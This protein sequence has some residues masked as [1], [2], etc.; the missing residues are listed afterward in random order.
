MHKMGLSL[1]SLSQTNVSFLSAAGSISEQQN[2]KKMAKKGF[3]VNF[4]ENIDFETYFRK[5]KV[6]TEFLPLCSLFSHICVLALSSA[7]YRACSL[8][9]GLLIPT[10]VTNRFPTIK[11]RIRRDSTWLVPVSKRHPSGLVVCPRMQC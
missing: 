11:K 1:S 2:K 7:R 9:R 6:C 3:E 10:H 4:D 5:T 8:G